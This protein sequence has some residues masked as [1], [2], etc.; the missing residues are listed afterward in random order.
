[1]GDPVN[2]LTVTAIV[3]VAMI[4]HSEANEYQRVPRP[5]RFMAVM[6]VWAALGLIAQLGAPEIA[7]ALS[8][9]FLLVMLY[10]LLSASETEVAS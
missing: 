9:G 5:E 2:A 4:V 7:G 8:V 10:R 1:M 3:A 6:Y